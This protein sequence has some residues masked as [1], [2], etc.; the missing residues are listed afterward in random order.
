M[1][2]RKQNR[3]KKNQKF[4]RIRKLNLNELLQIRG[5]EGESGEHDFD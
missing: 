4:I 1:K 5:G 3:Q 2:T